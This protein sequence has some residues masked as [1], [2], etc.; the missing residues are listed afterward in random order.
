LSDP[1]WALARR[2]ASAEHLQPLGKVATPISGEIM[3]N[4]AMRP[5]LTTNP[6]HAL[7]LRGGHVQ[8]YELI[9]DPK[10]GE[11]VYLD[12]EKYLANST[13]GTKAYHH[14]KPR[15]VFQ[16]SAALDNWRRI[17]ATYI[18]ADMFCGHTIEYFV[19]GVWDALTLL[20]VFN[21]S[22]VEWRFNIVS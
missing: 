3:F 17:I 10:Q 1:A 16:E 7:V 13:E 5:Y 12:S 22:L 21:S 2:L 20:A 6:K 11:P 14:T 15:V 18:P 4:K 8:R 19:D 9:D